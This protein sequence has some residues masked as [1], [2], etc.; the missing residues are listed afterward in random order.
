MDELVRGGRYM[1]VGGFGGWG[2][3]C[4]KEEVGGEL[5][6]SQILPEVRLASLLK[7]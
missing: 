5:P 6:Q 7:Q 1:K 2:S 3:W 4:W